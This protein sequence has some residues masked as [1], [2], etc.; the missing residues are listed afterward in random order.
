M[1]EIRNIIQ[2]YDQ[3][4]WSKNQVA[5]ATVVNVEESAYRRIGARMLVQSSGVWTGGISGGCL[6]ADALKRAK[7]AILKDE[8]SI[9]VYD[10]LEE[11]A[12]QIGVGLGCNGRI[13]VLFTPIS[14][15]DK[16]NPIEQ[17]RSIQQK[18]TPTVFY[19]VIEANNSEYACLGHFSIENEQVDF[20]TEIGI[21]SV[22]LIEKTAVVQEK[23]KSKIFDFQTKSG[24]VLQILIEFIRP[25]LKLI[26]VGDNYDVNAFVGIADEMGWEVNVVG[27][28]RKLAKSIFKIAK[29]IVHY[30]QAKELEIDEYTAVILMSH[31]FRWDKMVLPVFLEKAP[32]YIGMLGPKKRLLKMQNELENTHSNL[33][34]SNLNYL[35]SP[36]GLD[37]GAETPEEIALSIAAEII[38]NF[39]GRKGGFLKNRVGTIYIRE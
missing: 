1:K 33:D 28:Q 4:D 18:R 24:V 13:E 5:L 17:L 32:M 9:V 29:K 15:E 35:F 27:L 34:L 19:Q 31:D 7:V 39:R 22:D 16:N 23:Q 8:P 36:V 38:A 2:T 26:L 30:D 25:E 12:H 11:D 20:C 6:E 10:T 21:S 3:M 37:I 14:Q